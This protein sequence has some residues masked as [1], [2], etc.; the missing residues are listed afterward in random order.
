[1]ETMKHEVTKHWNNLLLT[2]NCHSSEIAML[3][4]KY[5]HWAD[6]VGNLGSYPTGTHADWDQVL[7]RPG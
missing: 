2:E 7:C 6:L 5:E 1:M 4:G 3:Y